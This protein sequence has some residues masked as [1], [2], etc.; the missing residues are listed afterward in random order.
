MVNPRGIAQRSARASTW[1]LGVI[2]AVL[3]AWTLKATYLVTMPLAFSFFLSVLV[4]PVQHALRAQLPRPLRWLSVVVVVLVVLGVLA[5]GTGLVWIAIDRVAEQ[6][7]D[8]AR[9]VD[10][11][12]DQFVRWAWQRDVEVERHM[13]E[14]E[15]VRQTLIGLLSYGITSI[16]WGL[17]MGAL[18]FFLVLL[19]LLE[20]RDWREK[21]RRAFRGQLS[22]EVLD[23]VATVAVK[24]RRYL[25]LRTF[26]SMLTGVIGG[27][28]L[29]AMDV[30]FAYV[31]GLLLFLFNYIPN[32]GSIVAVIPPSLTAIIQY[33]LGRGLIVLGGLT[34][35]QMFLGNFLEP[36]LEG[37]SLRVSPIVLMC[38]LLLWGWIWGIAGALLAVPM[39]VTIIT[40]CAHIPSLRPLAVMLSQSAHE[41]ID[42]E[43]VLSREQDNP[44]ELALRDEEK[45]PP[46]EPDAPTE[47]TTPSPS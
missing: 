46:P 7:P 44:R 1:L 28:W 2:A 31:W 25:L 18:I 8:Y 11:R 12:W 43:A 9:L 37:K 6:A 20:V 24:L 42:G 26:I 47:P 13:V 4:Y 32:I 17:A 39:T 15:Q 38:S 16:W 30:Q 33:G 41:P 34:V 40:V 5:A 3:V 29:W 23:M 19:V 14:S 35:V 36:R 27:T 10:A 21:S 22:D 45:E